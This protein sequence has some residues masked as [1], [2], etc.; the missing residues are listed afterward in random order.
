MTQTAGASLACWLSNGLIPA[1]LGPQRPH[2][3]RLE[4]GP[5]PTWPGKF[6]AWGGQEKPVR[7]GA[8]LSSIQVDVTRDEGSGRGASGLWVSLWPMLDALS[9]Q[10][11]V[12]SP[13]TSGGR[14]PGSALWA[15]SLVKQ[16]SPHLLWRQGSL[17]AAPSVLP[18]LR[19]P[20]YLL[21]RWSN[22]HSAWGAALLMQSLRLL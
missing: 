6:Q 21:A 20:V 11:C 10:Q 4:A 7:S 22:H 8:G 14:A 2:S 12:P 3:G 9:T 19:Y 1:N 16:V 13:T 18:G 5:V 15:A 17:S